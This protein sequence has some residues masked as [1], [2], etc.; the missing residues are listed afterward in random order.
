V[1]I[2]SVLRSHIEANTTLFGAGS[3][4]LPPFTMNRAEIKEN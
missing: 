4:T 1:K 2:H 3:V